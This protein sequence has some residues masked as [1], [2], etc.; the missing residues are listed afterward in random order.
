MPSTL[1]T[2]SRAEQSNEARHSKAASSDYNGCGRLE[3]AKLDFVELHSARDLP[4][5]CSVTRIRC[6]QSTDASETTST[7]LAFEPHRQTLEGKHTS[8]IRILKQ[9]LKKVSL[10]LRAQFVPSLLKLPLMWGSEKSDVGIRSEIE[11]TLATLY[12]IGFVRE[13]QSSSQ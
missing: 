9:F 8:G 2:S 3:A 5:H 11:D 13:V 4:N 12:K 10:P 7:K 6:C 1:H